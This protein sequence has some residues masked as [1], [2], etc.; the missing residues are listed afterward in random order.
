MR[1]RMLGVLVVGAGMLLGTVPAFAHHSFAAEFDSTKPITLSGTVTKVQ[2]MN[3]HAHFYVDV[4]DQN[5]IVTNWDFELGSP[6]V[7]MREGWTRHALQ[8]GDQVTVDGFL[9]KDG[10]HLANARSVTLANGRKVLAG[11]SYGQ[12]AQ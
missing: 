7:L 6:N 8:P 9:A 12:K 10:S 3:P 5:G 4:K 11:S 2:W 1:A